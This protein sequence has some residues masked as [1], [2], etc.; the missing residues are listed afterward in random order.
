MQKCE[1]ARFVASLSSGTTILGHFSTAPL[2][3]QPD[4]L[5]RKASGGQILTKQRYRRILSPSHSSLRGFL[6]TQLK[7][8]LCDLVLLRVAGETQIAKSISFHK[9][10]RVTLWNDIGDGIWYR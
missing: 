6:V 5:N 4:L 1:K 3:Q 10:K 2:F 7:W 8:N 9:G